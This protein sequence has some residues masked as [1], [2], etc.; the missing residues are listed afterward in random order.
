MSECRTDPRVSMALRLP[1][2][3]QPLLTWLTGRPA[4]GERARARAPWTFLLEAHAW[5]VLGLL[6]GAL[7]FATHGLTSAAL[8]ALSLV[9]TTAGLSLFQIAVFHR[10]AHGQLF[11]GCR[12]NRG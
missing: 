10:C 8:I 12:R 6:I 11:A 5:A 3:L 9:M 1:R 4:P 2:A 7:G